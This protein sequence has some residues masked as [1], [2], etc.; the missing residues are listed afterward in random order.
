MVHGYVGIWGNE[1]F[2]FGIFDFEFIWDLDAK[3]FF[4]KGSKVSNLAV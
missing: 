2:G 4:V 3:K 1:N